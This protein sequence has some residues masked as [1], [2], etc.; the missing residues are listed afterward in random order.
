MGL[1]GHEYRRPLPT[2]LGRWGDINNEQFALKQSERN[3]L[4]RT[5][6]EEGINYFDAT[7][8]EEAR[9]LG[10]ALG[11]LG[12]RERV[13]VAAM[14]IFPFRQLAQNSRS[15]WHETVIEAVEERF[16]L[17]QTD[18][19]E[20][21]NIHMPEDNYSRERLE[22]T[23]KA[24]GE[25]KD[26][27][28]VGWV[29]ASSHEPNFL[30]EIMRKYDCF[31]SVMVRYNYHLQEAREA[32]F[33]LCKALN[34]GVVIMKPLSWPFYGIPF[35]RFSPQKEQDTILTPAQVCLRWIL[36]SPEVSTVVPSIN[37]PDELQENVEAIPKEGQIQ[38]EVLAH[39]LALAKSPLGRERL[40]KMLQ[41]PAID[42]RH[43]AKRALAG[44]E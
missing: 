43:F 42:I 4:I 16:R 28:T 20:V 26:R 34:V 39:H 41:D 9:S 11:E 35:T 7:Q 23:L 24:I 14:I 19:V 44:E 29:G 27:G 32:L 40:T 12:L 5:A 21:L 6:V 13:N 10:I 15:K 8:T 3:A 17:L 2:T 31:D 38:E 1:G 36:T 22:V 37:S 33:P 18:H 30:A 25:M